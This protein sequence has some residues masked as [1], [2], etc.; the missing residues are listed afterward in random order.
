MLC[1][2][3]FGLLGL[4]GGQ[5]ERGS[6]LEQLLLWHR[7]CQAG[8]RLPEPWGSVWHC[9]C[10]GSAAPFLCRIKLSTVSDS[11]SLFHPCQEGVLTVSWRDLG[12]LGLLLKKTS[13]AC[14]ASPYRVL[15]CCSEAKLPNGPHCLSWL[16]LINWF[17]TGYFK[18]TD[19]L[20]V[21]LVSQGLLLI[22]FSN[23][24]NSP[25]S[26]LSFFPIPAWRKLLLLLQAF[27]RENY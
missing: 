26:L 2:Q 8:T 25:A 17:K 1:E 11:S 14:P 3:C 4:L 16:M 13:T 12:W 6:Q 18:E 27:S 7:Q 15:I 24:I 23:F 22:C 9:C 19:S 20:K 5:E 10:T 21:T